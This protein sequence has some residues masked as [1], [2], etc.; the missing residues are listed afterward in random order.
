VLE[1]AISPFSMAPA[2]ADP[3]GM[4]KDAKACLAAGAAIVHHHH[5]FRQTESEAIDEM[6]A[7]GNDVLA[8][9]PEAILY[10]DFLAGKTLREKIAHFEPLAAAGLLGMAP[11]DPG[12][13]VPF[14]LDE[15]GLPCGPGY[16]WNP[17][18]QSWEIVEVAGR[19]AVP[20]TVGVY[21]PIQLRWALAVHGAG[22]LPRGSMIKLY[23]GGRYSLFEPGRPALNFGLPP[24]PAALD[25]YLSMMEGSGLLW[26]AGV[27]GDVLLDTPL[28]HYALECGGH[29]RVGI[30]DTA[31]LTGATNEETVRAA[32]V[33]ADEVGRPI[34]TP[35][36][37]RELLVGSSPV[38][39]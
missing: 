23:F 26:N 37:A 20:I 13:A 1:A 30:E 15:A 27:M 22:K 12:A 16:V 19:C 10:P 14:G 9:Y 18:E 35:A 3:V 29:L 24:T 2:P 32:V 39:A 31:G 25:A 33:L 36:L 6:L 7:F 4:A 11:A 21:E 17:L 38:S 5:S 34:A 8:E 28:A